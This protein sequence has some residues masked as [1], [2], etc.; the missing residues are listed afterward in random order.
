MGDKK[1][2]RTERHAAM[3]RAVST[4]WKIAPNRISF[5]I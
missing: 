5:P 2:E 4:Q 1:G 3:V